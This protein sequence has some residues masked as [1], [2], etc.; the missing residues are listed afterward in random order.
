[1]WIICKE[2]LL[3]QPNHTHIAKQQKEHQL[4][5]PP[6]S[7]TKIQVKVGL[8]KMVVQTHDRG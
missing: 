5:K 1:M 3:Q 6:L 4:F 7:Q 2:N 8:S